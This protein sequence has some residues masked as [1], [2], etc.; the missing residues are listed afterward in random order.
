MVRFETPY[1]KQVVP[2]HRAAN[3]IG[4][5]GE[6]EKTGKAS[7]SGRTDEPAEGGRSEATSGA[8]GWNSWW[9]RRSPNLVTNDNRPVRFGLDVGS[10]TVKFVAVDADGH[11]V[12]SVYHR[13]RSDVRTTLAELVHDIIWRHGDLG[14]PLAV[15]GSAGIALAADLGV[16]FVQEV[17]ATTAAV[18]ARY[19]QA[20]CIIELGGEDAKITHLREPIE[21]RMNA[22]CAGGT[23]D[24][25]DGIASMLGVKTRE[26]SNLALGSFRTYDIASRCAVFAQTDVRPLINAGARREDIAQSVLEAVVRQTLGG[27][28]CGRPIRGTVVFLGGPLEHIPALVMTFRRKLGLTKGSG[29]KPLDA[30]LY[31]AIGAVECAPDAPTVML[32][33]LE[34]RLRRGAAL[35]LGA[36]VQ[37][38][39]DLAYLQPL[40]DDAGQVEEFRRRHVRSAMSSAWLGDARGDL[41]LGF[42]A[43]STTCKYALIDESGALVVSGYREVEGDTFGT[44]RSMVEGL[45]AAVGANMYSKE[46]ARIAHATVTG[47]GE[48]LLRAGLGFDSGVV[49]TV[50]HLKAAQH[51]CPDV[52]FMLD[53]GGQDMKALWVRDGV[54]VDAVLNEACSSG[55]GAFVQ[56]SARSLQLKSELFSKEAFEAR[57]PI[58]LGAKCTVFMTSRVRHAQ[59]IGASKG[60][61]AAGIAYSVV[62]NVMTR[63]IGKSHALPLGDAVVV[64]GGTFRSDAVLRA[65]EKRAGVRA[66]RPAAAHLMGAYGA[67][68]VARDRANGK[69]SSLLD[70]EEIRALELREK[71]TRCTGCGNAC[72]VSIVD[73]GNGRRFLS[74]N[75]CERAHEALFGETPDAGTRVANIV[76]LEQKLV[77]GF[78]DVPATGARGN[79]TVGIADAMNVYESVPFW[80][81][82]FSE[83]GFSIVMPRDD[84]AGSL[85]DRAAETIPSESVCHPAKVAHLRYAHLASKGADVVFMPKF[86]RGTRCPVACSYACAL[87]D[88]VEG[89]ALCSPTIK[90]IRPAALRKFAHDRDVLYEAIRDLAEGRDVESVGREEFERALERALAAQERFEGTLER[91]AEKVLDWL[92]EDESRR[93]AVVA[94]R[95]Y[96]ADAS[97]IHGID[98]ELAKLGFAVVPMSALGR[99]LRSQRGKR[100]LWK[101]SKHL[102]ELIEFS[103]AH[104]QIQVVALRSFGCGFDS[105]S[106]DE[107]RDLANELHRPFTELKIDEIVDRAHIRIRL[108]TLAYTVGLEGE[109]VSKTVRERGAEGR[110]ERSAARPRRHVRVA[111]WTGNW[112]PAQAKL[113]IG[114]HLPAMRPAGAPASDP[115]AAPASDPTAAPA[116]GLA[117]VPSN[118]RAPSASEGRAAQSG[119]GGEPPCAQPVTPDL[120][121]TAKALVQSTK[122]RL[123]GVLSNEGAPLRVPRVCLEC[124]TD[125]L[126]FE[127]EHVGAG[128]FPVEAVPFVEAGTSFGR[129]AS[130]AGGSQASSD[131]RPMV[132]LVGNPLLVFDDELNEH[133]SEL[134]ESLGW[135][136]A[137]PDPSLVEVEDVRYLE[138]L[139]AFRAA[140]VSRVIYLQSFGCLKGHVQSRGAAHELS[141]LFPDLPITFIDY[142]PESSALNRENRIRLALADQGEVPRRG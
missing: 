131:G 110:D 10:K 114:G 125:A 137:Y 101:P 54:V 44:A 141:G 28:A 70:A 62:N 68:L 85:R 130:F 126:P 26:I 127:L 37:A 4:E 25:I 66:T 69:A 75:R 7:E 97:L 77:A 108:R 133:V 67:A 103:A 71:S 83:L 84:E 95:P 73:F 2:P 21:Q 134:V 49:E 22:T 23:G 104:P 34:R 120:C 89:A 39:A 123:D 129:K 135:R 100:A 16:P 74:G 64:Q 35:S 102:C 19:P 119:R 33:D 136:V 99:E 18:R 112:D 132:G 32:S 79:V 27:L 43:G 90:A 78:G 65:F 72:L 91:A 138:Q 58:D 113:P 9:S 12:Y 87:A 40:F 13:H 121:S 47:Y 48:D 3:K 30:H 46:E 50:A 53:I 88:N 38:P 8:R 128:G 80:H 14:A 1:N 57:H 93:A 59:K 116:S 45:V 118:D 5:T 17:V 61:I 42:D 20:D 94:G 140:G 98:V 60:D 11:V 92:V 105:V 81:T 117:A 124:L 51:F 86:E 6:P 29:I 52:S 76:A 15:T 115:T 31:A 63:I 36:D 56:S 109:G 82:L 41:Y 55:C 139:E 24:F 122:R 96:H 142:D 107:A 106:F 111:S